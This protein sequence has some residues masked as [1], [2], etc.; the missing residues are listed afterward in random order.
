[1]RR[2]AMAT[3]GQA[4]TFE[5]R[6]LSQVAR[7]LYDCT[8]GLFSA[9][10]REAQIIQLHLASLQLIVR[11]G[12]KDDGGVIGE[13]TQ[14]LSRACESAS[15]DE[16][17]IKKGALLGAPLLRVSRFRSN[18]RIGPRLSREARRRAGDSRR[19]CATTG[20]RARIL[21]VTGVRGPR[22]QV[23]LNVGHTGYPFDEI[24]RAPLVGPVDNRSRQSDL[25]ICDRHL[26]IGGIQIGV[27]LSNGR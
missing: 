13:G 16:T 8:A 2:E 9:S 17:A 20:H 5:Y 22:P 11:N 19:F 26:D 1:M 7:S 6:L 18:G 25:A 10:S 3:M 21:F 14:T 27:P 4:E 12:I 24:F 23:V 15:R